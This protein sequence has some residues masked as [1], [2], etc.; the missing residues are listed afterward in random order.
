V[1]KI[2]PVVFFDGGVYFQTNSRGNDLVGGRRI[3]FGETV[4]D[5]VSRYVNGQCMGA[6]GVG[7]RITKYMT[8]IRVFVLV[9]AS[10]QPIKGERLSVG[11]ARAI[12]EGLVEPPSRS[13]LWGNLVVE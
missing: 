8:E 5:G 2:Y 13:N 11:E 6:L 9:N 7:S 1:T 4:E 3:D 10:Q 12:L